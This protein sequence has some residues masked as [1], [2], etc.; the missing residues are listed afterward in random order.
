MAFLTG[1]IGLTGALAEGGFRKSPYLIYQGDNTRMTVLWQMSEAT[2]TTLE[3]GRSE[4]DV[5]HSIVVEESGTD[6]FFH[7]EIDGL[8]PGDMYRYRVSRG[9]LAQEGIFCAAPE[10]DATSLSFFAIG[11]SRT[12]PLTLNNLAGDM[13]KQIA[14]EPSLHTMLLHT[15]DYVSDGR[16]EDMWDGEMFRPDLPALRSF[17][18]DL[19]WQGAIGNHEFTGELFLKYFPYKYEQPFY[20]SFDYGPLHCAMVD[21]Y[22]DYSPG[23]PQLLWL[24]KDLAATKKKW[25]ILIIHYAGWTTGPYKGDEVGRRFL[26][27]LCRRY[28]VQM[29]LAGHNHLYARCEVD[30]VTYITT[31]GGGGPLY[32]P[33]PSLPHLVEY[34]SAHH[35]V[36]FDI[37]GDKMAARAYDMDGQIIDSFERSSKVEPPPSAVGWMVW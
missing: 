22:Q 20:W 28:G 27:P 11:D 34:S 3:W 6:H 37:A 9:D 31:G 2:T 32:G 24:E 14:R 36:R 15:G 5:D 18:A 26:H 1:L 23:S 7:H 16:R 25:K 8:M 17:M 21:Q 35:F 33:D 12:Y 30:T 19:P 29:V 4:S 10:D 13:L